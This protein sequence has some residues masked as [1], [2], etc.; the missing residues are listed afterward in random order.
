MA[1][2]SC[3]LHRVLLLAGALLAASAV[4][5]P[6][7]PAAA[8][9]TLPGP[10]ALL[11]LQ[12]AELGDGQPA[13]Y[14]DFGCAVALDGDT[15]LVGADYKTIGAQAY[16]GAVFVYVRSGTGWSLQAALMDPG[17]LA[18]DGFGGAVALDGDTALVGADNRTVDGQR[19]AGAAYLY[20][21]SGG[22]WSL[23]A[24]LTAAVPAANDW[25]GSSVALDGDTAL[26]G[27]GGRTVGG[28]YYA[29][30]AYVFNR[31]GAVW[32]QQAELTA[33]DGAAGDEFGHAVALSGETALVGA[34][35]RSVGGAPAAGAAYVFAR[36]GAGWSQQAE[37]TAPDAA[38][39]AGFG[40]SLDLSGDTAL[41]GAGGA[42]AGGRVNSGAAYVYA[43]SGTTWS[44]QAELTDPD[45]AAGD[46]FGSS[47]A[48]SGDRAL[49]GAWGATVGGQERGRRRLRLRARRR[50]LDTACQNHSPGYGLRR[51][52][53]HVG[54]PRRRHGAGG[55]SRQ[56]GR[57]AAS[58]RRRLRVQSRPRSLGEPH[59]VPDRDEAGPPRDAER[60]CHPR[61]RRLPA[62]RHPA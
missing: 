40:S 60:H 55:R 32:S 58:C 33:G 46:W 47:L 54:G 59:G 53:R 14:E 50:R 41:I 37:L 2:R 39:R 35:N 57:R 61:G 1:L 26:V 51:Q 31:S 38:S 6:G 20:V 56:E 9:R 29:G 16:A 4:L 17:A 43:R 22:I 30:A 25:F 13:P 21:R 48:L 7:A 36:S 49:I 19:H 44:Q 10:P 23:Q 45:G 5:A 18:G 52:L 3:H 62:R 11:A 42:P 28:Q 8:A 34:E 24:E 27:A 12:D 15:A